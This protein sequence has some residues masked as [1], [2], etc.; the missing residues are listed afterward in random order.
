M[1]Y[2]INAKLVLET[3]IL[4]D[5]VLGIEDGKIALYGKKNEIEIPENAEIID[6]KGLYVGPGF[7]DIHVHGGNGCMFPIDPEGAAK[8]FLS[9]G[10][11]TILPVLYYNMSK[12]EYLEAI[13]RIKNLMENSYLGAVL[14]GF[15]MEGPY[16]NP[17]FGAMPNEN[18]WRGEIREE[19]YKEIVDSVGKLARV[20]SVAPE[21][22]GL[23]QFM[24]YAKSVNPDTVFSVGHS[25]AT[26]EEIRKL[27]KYGIKLQ[28]HCMDATGQQKV[29]EG[30][31]GA[32]PDEY[33][34]T[35]PDMYAEIICDSMGI[36]VNPDLIRMIVKVK[37]LEKVVLITD[38]FVSDCESPDCFKHITDLVFDSVGGINGSKLTMDVAC[39]NIMTHTNCGIA[40]A[41]LLASRNPARVAGLESE[42]GTI[43]IGKRA[44]LVFVDDMFNVDTV[45]LDGK[46]CQS[47]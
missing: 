39:R 11:T 31:R 22:E 10:E 25:M 19:D 33:C 29:Y 15:Y 44:N 38:S 23:E 8:H 43:E 40:Q 21:R 7:V 36:H 13:R 34:M 6:A 2:V 3:G 4:F 27:K 9:H 24:A 30:T 28:T 20:W 47:I 16:M 41:F 37:G 1:L 14:K 46:I 45:I 42:V 17:D 32:G 5:A 35:D 18:K 26:P 12:D